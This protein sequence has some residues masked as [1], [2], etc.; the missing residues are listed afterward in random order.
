M[1]RVLIG[2]FIGFAF[3]IVIQG[4]TGFVEGGLVDQTLSVASLGI[5]GVPGTAGVVTAG[6]LGGL[7]LS[8]FFAPVY[9]IVGALDGLFDMGRTGLNVFAGT[10]AATLIAKSEGEIGDGSPILS[11]KQIEKQKEIALKISQKE[12][13]KEIKLAESKEKLKQKLENKNNK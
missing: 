11:E 3:G 6:V 7:G 4:I 5:A 9:A 10:A 8:H 13:K 1:Y 2:M 12:E